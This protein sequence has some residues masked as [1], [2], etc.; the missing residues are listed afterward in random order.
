M[1]KHFYTFLDCARHMPELKH[2]SGEKFDLNDSEVIRWLWEQPE[3]K[4]KIFDMANQQKVIV[5]DPVRKTWK[6]C[7]VQ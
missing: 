2:K 6:G 5:Y 1:R 4:Q 7:E 3:I